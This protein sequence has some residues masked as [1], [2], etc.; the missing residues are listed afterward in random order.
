MAVDFK[1][2]NLGEGIESGD[3]AN[4]LVKEGDVI[5]ADQNVI[6]IE[7]GKASI[8][9]PSPH[10]GRVA[11][12]HVTQGQTVK[13]GAPL[14]SIEGAGAEKPAAKPEPAAPAAKPAP[15]QSSAP[16]QNG[17][18]TSSAAAS[19]KPAAVHTGVAPAGP[20]TRRLARELGVDLAE[21]D[22]SG[23]G[24]RITR[25][26]VVARVHESESPAAE[27]ASKPATSQP[28]PAKP[29]AAP[30]G[31]AGSDSFGAV[32]RTP[33]SKIRRLIAENMV[34]SATTIPHVTNFDSADITELERIRQGGLVGS[35]IKLTMLAFVI[36]AASHALRLHPT[37]N[38]TLDLDAGQIVHKEYVN[39]GVAV[40]TDRGLI[41]PVLR[42][43]DK[44]NIPQIAQGLTD[45]AARARASKFTPDDTRGGTFTISNLGA[46]GGV[47]S[48][49]IINPPEVGILLVGRSKKQ[50]VVMPD[51]SIQ[52]RLMLPLSL[53][54]DHRLV[55]GA[56][57]GR[58]LNE[59][60]SYL[61]N[62]GRLL[63]TP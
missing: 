38:S 19:A 43:I 39:L 32:R 44:L 25:E 8:E 29:A 22:G 16:K 18:S 3:I 26:D 48:T 21:V 5:T 14:M 27:P 15:A 12:I 57:A 53:S 35:E 28:S 11:K 55:D 13:I 4:L 47:F 54:Y 31:D 52:P 45:I 7:T 24:G 41:V 33:V 37:L 30:V 6:E 10:A 58:F 51:D 60:I 40:D 42:G 17:P 49:P 2:P 36:K 46:V 56:T 50:P 59:V 62:P 9:L 23:A 63:L 20:A 34:R 1:L 61:E